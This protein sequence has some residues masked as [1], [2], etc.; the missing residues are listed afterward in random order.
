MLGRYPTNGIH[1]KAARDLAPMI[2]AAAP[3]IEAEKRLP[4]DLLAALHEKRLFHML[5]PKSAGGEEVDVLTFFAAVE[6]VGGGDASAGW[7]VGQAG[8]VST[9]A[10]Y[11]DQTVAREIFGG[12]ASVVAWGP[13]SRFAKAVIVPGGYRVTGKWQFASGSR[14]AQWLGA[15]C[16]VFEADG[17]TPAKGADGRPRDRTMLLPKSKA[18]VTDVWRVMG[19]KGTGSD[20]YEVTDLFVPEEHTFTRD[21]DADRRVQSPLYRHFSNFNMFGLAFAGV[22]LGVAQTL[23]NDFEALAAEKAPQ[24]TGFQVLLR[25]NAVIQSKVAKAHARLRAARALV[26]NIYGDLWDQAV[27]DEPFTLRNR[28]DMRLAST[29]AM[30][31]AREVADT[32]YNAAGATAIFEERPFERRFRDINS[33]SQQ[34]QAHQA[35]YELIGQVYL[36]LSPKGRV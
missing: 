8:G 33:V 36:G 35:N 15:H 19:L 30:N 22:A 18:Q 25:D 31:E 7:C 16:A 10:A 12:H 4:D 23:L 27:R 29:F 21:S 13:N 5:S 20:S 28:A 32:L 9:V 1:D 2:S 3:R 11:L 6:A 17:V 14:H 26:V 24:A 34:G